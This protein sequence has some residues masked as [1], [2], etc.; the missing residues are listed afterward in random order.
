MTAPEMHTEALAAVASG[1]NVLPVKEDGTKAPDVREWTT[2][3]QRMATPDEVKHWFNNGKSRSG[4][5]VITGAISR[6]L[7][8]LDFDDVETFDSFRRDASDAGLADELDR[9][10]RGY[11]ETSPNGVHLLWRCDAIAGS[12]KLARRPVHPTEARHTDDKVRTLIETKGE[13]GYVI[14]AP[15]HGGVHETG[16]AYKRIRGGWDTIATVTPEMREAFL[17]LA[18]SFDQMPRREALHSRTGSIVPDGERPGDAFNERNTCDDLLVRHGWERVCERNGQVR[19]RRPG[20]DR[21]VSA[22][23]DY[24]ERNGTLK[25]FSTSTDFDTETTYS[26]FAVYAVLEHGGDYGAAARELHHQG[27]GS[28]VRQRASTYAT[29]HALPASDKPVLGDRAFHGVAGE[30]VNTIGPES[31]ADPAAL[32]IDLLVS[33]GNAIGP[34][35]HAYADGS[36][37]PARL[38]AV[39]VG[40][41]AKARKGTSR[42]V[43]KKLMKEADLFWDAERV[44]NGIASGEGLIAAVAA[45]PLDADGRPVGGSTDRR[46]LVIEEEYARMLK[47]GSRDGSTLSPTVRS[48]WDG[49][50]ELSVLTK[51][52]SLTATGAHISIIGHITM[53]ELQRTMKEVEI[54]NGFA[55]RFLF[56]MVSRA[57]L[58]P[59]GGRL[60]DSDFTRMGKNLLGPYIQ[61]ARKISLVTRTPDAEAVWA[62]MYYALANDLP[63]GVLGA[64]TARAEAQL[65]RLSLIYALLDASPKIEVE[66][67]HAARAVWDYARASAE[68]IFGDMTGHPLVERLRDELRAAYPDGLDFSQQSKLF[69]GHKSAA[70]LEAAREMLTAMGEAETREVATGGRTRRVTYATLGERVE[71]SA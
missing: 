69:D 56:M 35:P 58:L 59:T 24:T 13:G 3:Q 32:L 38:F 39:C 26:P 48:A 61:E 54:A 12:T 17:D 55:N 31:E 45:P 36:P 66:H 30:I 62:E 70:Q 43:I 52:D 29:V 57:R 53:D 14:T 51:K 8:C 19:L 33:C 16:K 65:L 2:R 60:T 20:K 22:T 28:P 5:A 23:V 34:S 10:E 1:C 46:L 68:C 15:S 63:G 49:R 4:L 41:T 7:E 6:N 71:R 25:V 11:I 27:Y 64:V 40:D 47:V 42:S 37:H 50:G 44:V 21:G 9:I 67:L 18:R